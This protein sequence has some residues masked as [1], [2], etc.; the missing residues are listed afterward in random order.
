MYHGNQTVLQLS[1][2]H[3]LLVLYFRQYEDVDWKKMIRKAEYPAAQLPFHHDT[4][5]LN[6]QINRFKGNTQLS[7][8]YYMCSFV[9][10]SPRFNVASYLMSPVIS[11]RQISVILCM[12]MPRG[13]VKKISSS[14]TGSGSKLFYFRILS[15]LKKI[16]LTKKISNIKC[17]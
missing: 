17:K 13:R 16:V 15:K 14:Y 8:V 10:S 2:L 5:D 1:F 12:L 9:N 4:S 7:Q 3:P 11:K 6:Q